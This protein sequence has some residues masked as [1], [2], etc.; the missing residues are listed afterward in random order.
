MEAQIR[1]RLLNVVISSLTS[2]E[3]VRIG[4]GVVKG[5]RNSIEIRWM[6]A[7]HSLDALARTHRSKVDEIFIIHNCRMLVANP[8]SSHLSHV[9]VFQ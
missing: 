3:V 4:R 9:E 8:H 7:S 5:H 1:L 6:K 2:R